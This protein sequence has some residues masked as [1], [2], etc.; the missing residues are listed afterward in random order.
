MDIAPQFAGTLLGL[1]NGIAAATGFIAPYTVAVLTTNVGPILDNSLSHINRKQ[2]NL[3][4]RLRGLVY[5]IMVHN[6]SLF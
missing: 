6:F 3:K 5:K 1:T 2:C 4:L